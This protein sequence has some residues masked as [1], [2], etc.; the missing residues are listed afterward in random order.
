VANT[1]PGL[2]LVYLQV[3]VM[4]AISVAISTRLPFIPNLLICFTIWALGHLTPQL[5]QSQV[6]AES[7]PPVI[8]FSKMIATVFPVLDHFDVQASVAG[9]RIVPLAYLGWAFVYA[10]IYSTIA[11]LLALTLFEDRDLA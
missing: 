9:G 3:V 6:V 11:M 2:V 1:V 5:V 8:F 10:A 4:T 7:L